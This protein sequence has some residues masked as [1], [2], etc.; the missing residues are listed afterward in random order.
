[1]FLLYQPW[2]LIFLWILA[3]SIPI[4]C[5]Y[6]YINDIEY[7]GTIYMNHKPYHPMLDTL[8][9]FNIAMNAMAH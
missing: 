3:D 8:W 6:I 5:M 4:V 9:L 2:L 7:L 1:M